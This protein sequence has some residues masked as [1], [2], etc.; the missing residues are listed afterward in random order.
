VLQLLVFP[1]AD[2]YILSWFAIAPLLVAMLRARP[3]HAL[4]L[5]GAEKLLPAT[6]AQG[7]LLGYACGIL[8][9]GGTCYWVFNTMKQYGGIGT[10]GAAGL[11]ALFC[12]YLAL[13]HGAFGLIISL[14]ARKSLRLA[15]IGA[16]FAWVA[17][18]LARTR[19]T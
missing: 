17:M 8:W 18:E 7:F 19:I 11:L 15:L 5:Q 16:P 14:L 9:Y 13:Y 3:P 10:L 1:L 12:L 6:P 4:Q 2:I